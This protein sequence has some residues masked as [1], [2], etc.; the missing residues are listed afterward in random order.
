VARLKDAWADE[1]ARW[2]KR[3]LSARRYVYFWADGIH[4]QARLE[5]QAQCLL[6]IIGTTPEGRKELAGLIDG[7]RESTLSWRELLLDLRRRGLAMGAEKSWRR[8]DGRGP[9]AK[10]DPGCKVHR[11]CRSRQATASSRRLTHTVTKIA[12]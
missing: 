12:L 10:G 1:H 11:R 4:L 2:C 5:D 7:V 8:L 3:D 6:V 9:V